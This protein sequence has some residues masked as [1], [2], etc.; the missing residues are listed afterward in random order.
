MRVIASTN[1]DL[2]QEV[3]AGNF[4]E[5][6]YYRLHVL[7]L[8]IAALGTQGGHPP[9]AER[10]CEMYAAQN[11]I[12]TPALSTEACERRRVALARQRSRA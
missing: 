7:P 3:A 6:L 1:R 9:L 4:R 8:H 10:F 2:A 11:G 12:A 5:D